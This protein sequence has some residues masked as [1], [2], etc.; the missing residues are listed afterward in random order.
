MSENAEANTPVQADGLVGLINQLAEVPEPAPVSMIPQ[1]VGWAVLAG[2]LGLA[3]LGWAWRIWRHYQANAYR[4]EALAALD[5]AASDAAA[6]STILKR[7]ALT[8]YGRTSVAALS[9]DDWLR[10]LDK[11]GGAAEGGFVK[12]AGRILAAAAYRPEP[13]AA[14][15]DLQALARHWIRNHP[16]AEALGADNV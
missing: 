15:P 13:V 3:L 10:F 5:A 6:I 4:R 16:T 1:T 14:G 9:G 2:A 12:G 7:A 11:T 8:A